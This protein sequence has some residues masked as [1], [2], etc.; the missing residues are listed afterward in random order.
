MKK[1][2]TR[3]LKRRQKH[4]R[5]RKIYRG[6][7]QYDNMILANP[8]QVEKINEFNK[9]SVYRL[10]LDNNCHRYYYKKLN[11]QPD[12]V[13][14]YHNP[15]NRYVVFKVNEQLRHPSNINEINKADIKFM[16]EYGSYCNPPL[17]DL[18]FAKE[19]IN[20][21]NQMLREKCDNLYLDVGYLY[22]MHIPNGVFAQMGNI[23][24]NYFTI[25]LNNDVGCVSSITFNI[26]EYSYGEIEFESATLKEYE[27]R[28]YNK[29]LRCVLIL[30]AKRINDEI[31]TIVSTAINPISAHLIMKYFNGNAK[32]QDNYNLYAFIKRNNLSETNLM[33]A[34]KAYYADGNKVV[35]I[36]VDLTPENIANAKHL[37][38]QII[39]E[40]VCN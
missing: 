37:L 34:I 25:C 35:N 12:Y 5:K 29:L 21:I 15:I 24:E 30:I 22:H 1:R 9:S 17:L 28:K 20:E 3:R 8:S 11:K 6:G 32:P 26:L 19:K 16:D 13:A 36:T 27:G 18:S 31:D 2:K 38:P 10:E 40:V 39:E 33:D 7:N 4:S 14:F 23:Y